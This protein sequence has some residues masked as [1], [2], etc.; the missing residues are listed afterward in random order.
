M[1]DISPITRPGKIIGAVAC[2]LGVLVIALPTAI[3]SSGFLEE[4]RAQRRANDADTF[5]S[6]PHCGEQL[7]P[8]EELES[9]DR[10]P[11]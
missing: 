10:L 4:M 9:R 1:G 2:V 8:D 11:A 3:I 7:M 6:C 5:G